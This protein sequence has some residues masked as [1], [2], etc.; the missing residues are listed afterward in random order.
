MDKMKK[1]KIKKPKLQK[2]NIPESDSQHLYAIAYK[3]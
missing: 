1:V 3:C 2:Q